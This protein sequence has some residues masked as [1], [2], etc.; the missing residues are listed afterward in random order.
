MSLQ[1][2]LHHEPYGRVLHGGATPPLPY[3]FG[4]RLTVKNR[5]CLW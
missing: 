3:K 2:I 1:L 5:L 4:Y